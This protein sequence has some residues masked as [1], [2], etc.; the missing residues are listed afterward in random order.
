MDQPSQSGVVEM[1]RTDE[2]GRSNPGVAASNRRLTPRELDVLELV[3]EGY[4]T[5]EIARELWI[6]ADTVRTHIKRMMVRL[7]ARTRAHVVAI[8]FRE[9]LWAA[10]IRTEGGDDLG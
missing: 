10:S 1:N 6:T 2:L 7:D 3:A 9:G 8:A 5:A 4:S